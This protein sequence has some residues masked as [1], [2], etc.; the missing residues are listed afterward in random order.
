LL[1]F[2]AEFRHERKPLFGVERRGDPAKRQFEYRDSP[3]R[4]DVGRAIGLRTEPRGNGVHKDA[5][6]VG[7]FAVCETAFV[8]QPAKFV[9]VTTG[10]EAAACG[11]ADLCRCLRPRYIKLPWKAWSIGETAMN[12]ISVRVQ[13]YARKYRELASTVLSSIARVA[14]AGRSRDPARI[15]AARE[16]HKDV[17]KSVHTSLSSAPRRDD[18]D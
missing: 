7:D 6:Q 10:R 11:A 18:I 5:E 1:I 4:A 3:S 17:M 13:K 9:V 12:Q 2:V 8:A 15:D 16:E 14:V